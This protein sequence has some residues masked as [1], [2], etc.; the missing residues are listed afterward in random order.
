ME[1]LSG[2]TALITGGGTG[3]GRG[4]ALMLA[5]EGCHVAVCGRRQTPLDK[6]LETIHNQG[7]QALAVVGDVSEVDDVD[8]IIKT[9]RDKFGQIDI[10]VNNAGIDGGSHIH[11]HDLQDWDRVMAIN[12]RGPLSVFSRAFAEQYDT[13]VF[14]RHPHSMPG[15]VSRYDDEAVDYFDPKRVEE[16]LSVV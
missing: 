9:S 2:K 4:V 3:I 8:R 5:G 7:G 16:L 11:N 13:I 6:V 10:L 1:E 14:D 12:L 15:Y